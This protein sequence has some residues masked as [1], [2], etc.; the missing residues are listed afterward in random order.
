MRRTKI[1]L[2]LALTILATQACKRD[3]P[4]EQQP[5]AETATAQS[6]PAP[7]PELTPLERC[8]DPHWTDAGIQ[9]SCGESV[10]LVWGDAQPQDD[11]RGRAQ[12]IAFKESLD[13]QRAKQGVEWGRANL[14]RMNTGAGMRPLHT[15]SYRFT[16]RIEELPPTDIEVMGVFAIFEDGK[17]AVRTAHCAGLEQEIEAI[18]LPV[19]AEFSLGG[20]PPTYMMPT[21]TRGEENSMRFVPRLA[22]TPITIPEGCER[23]GQRQITC[24]ETQLLWE[25]L[26][27][28][29]DA[30]AEAMFVEEVA[31]GMERAF[32]KSVSK[33][34]K[35]CE[36]TSKQ[37]ECTHLSVSTKEERGHV[38]IGHARVKH[39]RTLVMCAWSADEKAVKLPEVCAQA[40]RLDR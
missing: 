9:W 15:I 33:A 19:L 23:T 25:T 10:Q 4:P 1:L 11:S 39:Q 27:E 35:R 12:L 18:C 22:D 14:G 31:A 13:R 37:A 40:I 5:L 21:D 6:T 29:T 7:E 20:G 28:E 26:A 3:K 36:I 2:P 30:R 38:L 16:E 8:R 17:D 34:K 24:G 32:G